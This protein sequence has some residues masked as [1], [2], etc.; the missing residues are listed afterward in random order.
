LA[1]TARELGR[2]VGVP[3]LDPLGDLGRRLAEAG[4]AEREVLKRQPEWLGVRELPFEQVEARLERRQL[5]VGQLERG[6]E[7]PLGPQGVQLL[8]RE[9]VP[10]RLERHAE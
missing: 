4:A 7:V 8:A 5:L 10:L 3:N 9:L 6:Q 2:V 1:Q